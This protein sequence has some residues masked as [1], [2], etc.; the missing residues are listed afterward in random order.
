M[1]DKV[2]QTFNMKYD[3]LCQVNFNR[4]PINVTVLPTARYIIL[5]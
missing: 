5:V 1:I 4:F 2:T 3:K